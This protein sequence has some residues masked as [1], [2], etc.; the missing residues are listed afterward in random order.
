M[1]LAQAGRLVHAAGSRAARRY[2]EENLAPLHSRV[3]R[4]RAIV[5][6]PQLAS[7]S[8]DANDE[9]IR[10]ACAHPAARGADWLLL[11]DYE[12]SG[13]GRSVLFFFTDDGSQPSVVMKIGRSL[14][15]EAG[16]LRALP[17]MP[18]IPRVEDFMITPT[19]ELLVLTGLPGRPLSLLM[20]R[21]LRP[22]KSHAAHLAAAG[23]W[24]GEFHARTGAVHGDFWPRNVLLTDGQVTGVVDWEHASLRG[25][26]WRDVFMLVIQFMT[27]SPGWR[28]RNREREL[29]RAFLEESPL[30]RI[31]GTYFDAYARAAGISRGV[32]RDEFEKEIGWPP[33]RSVFSG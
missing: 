22:R 6:R 2:A 31:A 10:I 14:S 12:E 3:A 28:A 25:E 7:R 1:K 15:H 8:I 21:S 20:Q 30:A 11:R 26:P 5:R 33:S 16:I 29:R 13:R 9:V 17:A 4:L 32:L 18:S 24:L 23:A 19:H 27:A